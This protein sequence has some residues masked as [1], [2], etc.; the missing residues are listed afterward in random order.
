MTTRGTYTYNP[1]LGELILYA[2]NLAG[3]RSTAI[4]QEHMESARMSA[5]L[6]LADWAN[7][8]VNLWAVDLITVPLVAGQETYT[9]DANTVV[10]LDAYMSIDNGSSPPTDRLI[11]PISRS[12]YASYPNKEMQGFTTTYWFD[13]LLSPTVTLWPVPDGSSAQYLKYYRVR[14]IQDGVVAGGLNVEIPYLWLA[15]FAFNLGATLS[16]IWNPEKYPV[17]APLAE[18]TYNTAAY[19]NTETASMYISPMTNSYWRV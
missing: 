14:Q 6:V 5:N 13:R 1:S 3:V 10:I 7:Q 4:A 18:K 16:L 17:L 9:V 19:Q 8:G 12:E 15:A 2:Y 11:M